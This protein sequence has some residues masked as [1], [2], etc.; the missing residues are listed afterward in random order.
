MG[1]EK[2]KKGKD[3]LEDLI[4]RIKEFGTGTIKTFITLL[5]ISYI[6]IMKKKFFS[7]DSTLFDI[8]TF[9]IISS[10]FLGIC[11]FI[12]PDVVNGIITGIG[13]GLGIVILNSNINIDDDTEQAGGAIM[14]TINKTVGSLT[15]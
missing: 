12:Y 7:K 5:C 15:Y 14:K 11:A 10:I 2:C 3:K 9:C 8:V 1:D 4:T 6:V 13:I